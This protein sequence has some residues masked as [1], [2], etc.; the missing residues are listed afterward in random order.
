MAVTVSESLVRLQRAV[1]D[2]RIADLC[3]AHGVE[4]MVLFGSAVT[5]SRAARD[6]DIAVRYSREDDRAD[7]VALVNDLIEL[8]DFE[9][10]DVMDVGRA[11]PVA[12]YEALGYGEVVYEGRMGLFATSQMTAIRQFIDTKPLRRLQLELMG[13]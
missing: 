6:L 1:D 2:G 5:S 4:L 7:V 12:A 9:R 13:S 11:G 8:T 3:H 10:V